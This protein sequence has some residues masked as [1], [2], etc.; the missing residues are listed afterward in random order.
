MLRE[1]EI[2]VA[3]SSTEAAVEGGRTGGVGVGG[4]VVRKVLGFVE[5]GDHHEV[6]Q[7]LRP[8]EL[9]LIHGT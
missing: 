8:L 1:M 6:H 5:P 9:S 7:R 2:D 3:G 4:G